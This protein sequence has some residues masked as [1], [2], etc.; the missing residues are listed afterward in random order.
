PG[1]TGRELG[2]NRHRAAT[3]GAGAWLTEQPGRIAGGPSRRA[4]PDV[5]AS[6]DGGAN[7]GLGGCASRSDW[8]VARGAVG[9]R[10]GR[11]GRELARHRSGSRPRTPRLARRLVAVPATATTP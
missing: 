11:S 8:A 10:A 5:P 6:R 9:T 7:P 4:E 1:S 3:R 2:R